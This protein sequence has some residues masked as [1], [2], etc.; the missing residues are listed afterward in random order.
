MGVRLVS[1][2]EEK[3]RL[4]A[5]SLAQLGEISDDAVVTHRYA[6]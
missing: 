1:V 6:A 5:I 4:A 3:M 2:R